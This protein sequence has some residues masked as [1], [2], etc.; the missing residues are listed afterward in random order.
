M[1][2][3][4][5][6]AALI[7]GSSRG[8]GLAIAEKL[9]RAGARVVIS[10]RDA[11]TCDAVAGSLRADSLNA[12]AIPC[13]VSR[14]T[15]VV[16]LVETAI[17]HLGHIDILVCN[18]AA[19]PAYGPS[20]ETTDEVFDKITDT[21]VRSPFWLCNLLIPGM[22]ERKHGSVILMSSVTALAGNAMIGL[23]GVSKAATIQL[24][25]NLAVE[26][27]HR[28]VRVNCIAPG[29]IKTDFAKALW[30]NPELRA[31]VEQ[32]TPLGRIGEPGDI[33]GVA[34]FLASNASKFITGQVLVVDGGL[35]I[36][37]PMQAFGEPPG[38]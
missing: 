27:G 12:I 38:V 9:A 5:G 36:G 22:A 26:W 16:N 25:R 3:L 8:I 14:K 24:T 28:N 29:L 37:D 17:A 21:N 30:G 2:D 10:S 32:R 23:Y 6:K 18:A 19:N 7:T 15:E 34:L 13:N 20:A 31:R 35:M 4:E 1:S 11:D 33:S